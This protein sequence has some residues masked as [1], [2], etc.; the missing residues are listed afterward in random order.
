MMD[1]FCGGMERLS[2]ACYPLRLA[3]AVYEAARRAGDFAIQAD[4]QFV[5]PF[6]RNAHEIFDT[7]RQAAPPSS[8][9]DCRMAILVQDDGSIHMCPSAGWDL[10]CLRRHHGA[11][12]AYAV[13]RNQARV[14]VEARSRVESCTLETRGAAPLAALGIGQLAQYRIQ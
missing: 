6:L 4:K 10:E 11:A 13:T 14:R 1:T 2:L 3:A 9:E 5:S 12:M 8:G 7:A